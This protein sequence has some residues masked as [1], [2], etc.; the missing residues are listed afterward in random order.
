MILVSLIKVG[1]EVRS[2][3]ISDNP[4][5]GRLLREAGETFTP[6]TITINTRNTVSEETRLCDGDRVFIGNKVKGNTPYVVEFIRL[7]QGEVV[8]VSSEGNQTISQ[9]IDMMS[10]QSRAH[11]VGADGKEVFQ[12]QIS[13]ITKTGSDIVPTPLAEG[14]TVRVICATKVKGN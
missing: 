5:L 11:F 13:G 9:C 6:N 4:T 2:F 8:R 12:Y 7:G 3:E 10:A 14:G 1:C